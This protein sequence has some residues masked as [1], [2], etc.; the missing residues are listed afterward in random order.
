MKKH[1]SGK[2]DIEGDNS[3]INKD[4][5]KIKEDKEKIRREEKLGKDAQLRHAVSLLS[6]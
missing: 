2:A 6:G 4:E 1:L 3:E 5:S